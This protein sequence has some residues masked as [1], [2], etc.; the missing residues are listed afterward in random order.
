[1]RLHFQGEPYAG[2][3][4]DAGALRT[5]LQFQKIV[6]EAARAVWKRNHPERRRVPKGFDERTQ[7]CF[8]AIEPGSAAILLMPRSPGPARLL[9]A[10]TVMEEAVGL[11]YETF[12]AANRDEAPPAGV[13][14]SLLR[15]CLGLG[16]DLPAGA[17]FS[18]AP[19]DRPETVVSRQT[20]AVMASL[21]DEPYSDL[22]ELEGRVL[23]ADVRR[24]KFQLWTDDGQCV[25]VLFTEPQ[26]AVVT[27][28]L[29]DHR[30][31]RIRVTGRAR[32]EP[33]GTLTEVTVAD[34]VTLVDDRDRSPRTD[35]P[36]IQKRI[37]EIFADVPDEEWERLPRD[38]SARVDHYIYGVDDK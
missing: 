17:R 23:E 24:W 11:A 30:M 32:F 9:D 12:R 25:P 19:R 14:T 2:G 36:L 21:M 28:A 1:M 26:E 18:F 4:L 13:S 8:A 15:S 27:G 29:K 20:H 22:V 16:S 37:A 35:P 5:V 10:P 34:S 33:M 7:L 3:A 31:A 6:T 38:L